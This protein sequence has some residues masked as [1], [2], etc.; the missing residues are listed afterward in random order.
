MFMEKVGGLQHSAR[1]QGP[2]VH[3]VAVVPEAGPVP[4]PI[5]WLRREQRFINLLGA[6]K[7]D[8]GIDSAC[9]DGEP[10]TQSPQFPAR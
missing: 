4:P 6:N 7:V 2:G 9:G 1:C 10:F 5:V 3:V 8:V